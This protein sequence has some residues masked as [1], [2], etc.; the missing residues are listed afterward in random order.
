VKLGNAEVA[1]TRVLHDAF[2]LANREEDFKSSIS[3]ELS[4][5]VRDT[6]E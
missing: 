2:K 4:L 5:F 6:H 1:K 3:R